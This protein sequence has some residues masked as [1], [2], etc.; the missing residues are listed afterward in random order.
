MKGKG[1]ASS[2]RFDVFEIPPALK[3]NVKVEKYLI[4]FTHELATKYLLSEDC[5]L[6]IGCGTGHGSMLIGQRLGNYLY[7]GCD[8]AFSALE[9]AS[10]RY[11]IERNNWISAN[12]ENLPF[13]DNQ[14]DAVICL[15]VIEHIENPGKLLRDIFRVLKKEGKLL[16]STP[17]R[18]IAGEPT[19]AYHLKHYTYPELKKLLKKANF[20]VIKSYGIN[21]RFP[22]PFC[23]LSSGLSKYLIAKSTL[24][25][26]LYFWAFKPFPFLGRSIF[27]ATQKYDDC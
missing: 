10:K 16:I 27:V 9:F 23:K 26:E 2:E 7:Y 24:L 3:D 20:E 22:P 5:I 15:E 13:K 14:F 19:G 1:V 11:G 25:I 12:G 8:V 6:E 4:E 21:G 18:S 17:N